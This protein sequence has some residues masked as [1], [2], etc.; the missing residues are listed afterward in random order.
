[1]K[2]K[3]D[4]RDFLKTG[5]L[6]NI[7][8]GI[9]QKELISLLGKT[10]MVIYDSKKDKYP[11]LI[12][13]GRVEF[14]FDS[15]DKKGELFCIMIQPVVAKADSMNLKMKYGFWNKRLNIKKAIQYL[16][17]NDI[18]Y[19]KE[20]DKF[21]EDD[22]FLKTKKGFSIH[23]SKDYAKKPYKYRFFELECSKSRYDK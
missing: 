16:K 19:T 18:S 1:M 17:E 6:K 13:Y 7:P 3:E 9:N 15:G 20:I 23:F 4:F 8:F 14:L 2:I 5:E 21:D 11:G 10:K 22:I 12:K